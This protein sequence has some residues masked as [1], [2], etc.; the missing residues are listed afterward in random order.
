MSLLV[1]RRHSL[2]SGMG[3]F[4]HGTCLCIIEAIV[5]EGI[6]DQQGENT[7]CIVLLDPMGSLVGGLFPAVSADHFHLRGEA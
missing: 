1:S 6:W 3:W 2:L 7:R 5:E 4:C